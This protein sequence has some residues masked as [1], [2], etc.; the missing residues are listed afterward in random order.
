MKVKDTEYPQLKKSE[1]LADL[2]FAVDLFDHMNELNTRLQGKGNFAHEMY[3]TV[4]AFRV[5]LKLFSCQL[6]KNIT[7]HFST[8]ETLAPQMMSTEKYTNMI[9]ALDNEFALR[10]VDFQKLGSEFDI[11]SSPFTTD[12]EKVPDALQLELIDLQCDSTLKE[13][14]QSKSIEKFYASLN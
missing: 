3:S 1:W 12:F 6:S 8:L 7:T 10:F 13:K 9:S 14:F 2:A 4:K 11:L 5:K